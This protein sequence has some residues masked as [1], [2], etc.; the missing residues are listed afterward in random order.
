MKNLY[1][2]IFLFTLP[3]LFFLPACKT[4]KKTTSGGTGAVN[5]FAKAKNIEHFS[6]ITFKSKIVLNDAKNQSELKSPADIH[7]KRDS[8][9]WISA[10]PAM[11]IEAMRV[12][13]RKDSLFALD[14]INKIFYAYSWK[15][16][17][18]KLKFKISYQL[19]EELLLGN[20]PTVEAEWRE[21]AA[22]KS[23]TAMHFHV[24]LSDVFCKAEVAKNNGRMQ[25][26]TVN[27]VNMNIMEAEFLDFIK[28]GEHDTATRLK[29]YL[30]TKDFGANPMIWTEI[31][32]QKINFPAQSPAFHFSVPPSFEKK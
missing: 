20:L 24:Q 23:E 7:I 18:E 13:A 19:L 29:A 3:F 5:N 31:E 8:A 9:I 30:F 6:Y 12:L 32:H 16:L 25:K 21:S 10:R 11:G 27:D 22:E 2:G 4:S 17:S 1:K 26:L 15:S 14:R 28:S